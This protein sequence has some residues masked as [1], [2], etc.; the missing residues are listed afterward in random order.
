MT[1]SD[2]LHETLYYA[3]LDIR[4]QGREQNDKVVFHLSNL[5]HNVILQMRDAAEGN[6][7][8]SDILATLRQTAERTGCQEWLENVLAQIQ[9]SSD[10]ENHRDRKSGN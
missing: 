4:S 5:Y 3:L 8:Y 9:R 7:E 10:S 1:D 2:L 6:R